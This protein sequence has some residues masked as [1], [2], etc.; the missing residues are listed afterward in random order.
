MG[1]LA[2]TVNPCYHIPLQLPGHPFWGSGR[3]FSQGGGETTVS[4]G[5]RYSWNV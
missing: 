1:A 4:A 2:S 5:V 3:R